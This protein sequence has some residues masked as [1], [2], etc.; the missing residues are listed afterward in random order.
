MKNKKGYLRKLATPPKNLF[1]ALVWHWTIGLACLL[2]ASVCNLCGDYNLSFAQRRCLQMGLVST[3]TANPLLT[4]IASKFMQDASTYIGLRLAPLFVTGERSAQYYVWEKSNDV[5]IPK[6]SP[7]APGAAYPRSLSRMSDDNYFCQ[8]YGEEAVSPDE[9][10]KQYGGRFNLDRAEVNRVLNH[11]R[12]NHEYRVKTMAKALAAKSSPTTKWNASSGSKPIADIIAA[13]EAVRGKVGKRP[14]TI[15]IPEAVYQILEQHDEVLSRIGIASLKVAT[16][17]QIA[18]LIGIPTI[19]RPGALQNTANEGQAVTMGELWADDVVL[20]VVDP[21]RDLMALNA[22]RT[23]AWSGGDDEA[24]L[25]GPEG[26]AVRTY[27]DDQVDSN[28][29]KVN[30]FTDEK[31]TAA[32]A[33]YLLEDVLS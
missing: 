28:V 19:L 14:N 15:S 8:K 10:V 27:R 9:L 3:A 21:S 12:F 32:E 26:I 20:A 23:F 18:T 17:A 31:T 5:D 7:L 22:F 33:G 6:L 1:G 16:E 4:G 24:S 25:A 2:M 29:H 11:I 13:R 30:H